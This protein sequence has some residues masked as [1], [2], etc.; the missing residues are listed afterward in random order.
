MKVGQ[1]VF[2]E[3]DKVIQNV[4]DYDLGVFNGD[5]GW[6]EKMGFDKGKTLV[7]FQERPVLIP[8]ENMM[9]L[10]LA[11]AIT[12]HKSQGSEFDV[13]I[14]PM[15]MS[16]YIMLQ[17]NLVY[18]GLTRAKKLAIMI[19]NPKALMHA[20]RTMQSSLR[21]TRLKERIFNMNGD[22]SNSKPKQKREKSIWNHY[23][24]GH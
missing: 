4:N 23:Q 18:T 6:I 5:I 11:Y 8:R 10:R 9:N 2:R 20:S 1:Q 13:V 3:G 16:H 17:R 15:S 19:G 14:M 22:S 24:P 21:Q 7:R 12:I